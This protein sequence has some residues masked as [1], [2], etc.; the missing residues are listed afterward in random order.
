MRLDTNRLRMAPTVLEFSQFELSCGGNT[1]SFGV[2]SLSYSRSLRCG[3]RS[4]FTFAFLFRQISTSCPYHFRTN[5]LI[6]RDFL[7]SK[8]DSHIGGGEETM[9]SQMDRL[10]EITKKI[11]NLKAEGSVTAISPVT[12]SMSSHLHFVLAPH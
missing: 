11:S 3:I 6:C 2:A 9:L 12:N 8:R 4:I 10:S 1:M 5:H 7:R